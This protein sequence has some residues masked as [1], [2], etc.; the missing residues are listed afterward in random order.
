VYQ[1]VDDAPDSA[2]DTPVAPLWRARP[3]TLTPLQVAPGF[4]SSEDEGP[5]RLIQH[6]RAAED[7][8]QRGH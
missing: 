3:L 4:E 2:G 6:E 8:H 1:R 7:G 5:M